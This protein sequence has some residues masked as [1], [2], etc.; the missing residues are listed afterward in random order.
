MS[1]ESPTCEENPSKQ[2][3]SLVGHEII[4][5][6]CVC[7]NEGREVGKETGKGEIKEGVWILF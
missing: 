6:E 7:W 2:R 1:S 4:E 3:A 5:R